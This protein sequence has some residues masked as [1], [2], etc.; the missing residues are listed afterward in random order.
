MGH[1]IEQKIREG[2]TKTICVMTGVEDRIL[3]N[4]HGD[5]TVADVIRME[6]ERQSLLDE[7]GL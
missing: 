1:L 4:R 5:A 6:D 3:V 2:K 7:E